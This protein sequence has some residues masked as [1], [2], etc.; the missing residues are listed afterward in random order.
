MEQS[1][2]E[3][4]EALVELQVVD[5]YLNKIIQL[6]GNL[7][8]EVQDLEDV[9]LSLDMKIQEIQSKIDAN[10]K[11]ISSLKISIKEQ[12]DLLKK[13]DEQQMQVKNNREFEAI[14][15]EIE[16]THLEIQA[17]KRKIAI[18]EKQNGELKELLDVYQ[19]KKQ[20]KEK[21]LEIKQKELKEIIA[22]TEKEEKELN[23]IKEKIVAKVDKR[24]LNSYERIKRNMRNG[25]AVVSTDREACGGCFA[26]VPPQRIN[27]VKQFKKIIVCENC[28]RILVDKDMIDKAKE[29][30]A[31]KDTTEELYT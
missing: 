13:Y 12:E 5:S 16:I 26:V 25:L 8:F 28:G 15:K 1:I 19:E 29:K 11:N 2:K 23:N 18:A 27:E 31:I 9:I 7:P 3:K 10:K 21:D 4:L 6:R 20:S 14:S 30:L 17:F 24:L 22:M